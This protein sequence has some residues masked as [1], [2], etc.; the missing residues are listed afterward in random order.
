[1]SDLGGFS[2]HELFRAEAEQH[3][4][5]LSE[6]LVALEA[7][8]D[9]SAV[10]PLMRAA[11]SI[12]GAARVIGLEIAVGLSHAME[13]VLVAMQR[14]REQ[15]ASGRIDQLLRGT[16]LLASLARVDE[17]AVPEWTSSQA[18]AIAA[19][20]EALR[21]AVPAQPP[22]TIAAAP[23]VVD[24]VVV[25]SAVVDSPAVD[26]TAVDSTALESPSAGR[27][28]S[29]PTAAQPT[30]ARV[31]SVRIES[32]K[33]DRLLQL[34]GETMLESRRLAGVRDEALDLKQLLAQLG[35]EV[36][37]VRA[38]TADGSAVGGV[39][40]R[41]HALIERSREGV[42][43]HLATIEDAIRRGE[44]TST[45]LYNEVLASRMRPFG[46]L[47]AGLPRSVRDL[48]R[49][50]GKD[51]RIEI[52]GESVPVDRDVL[53]RIEAPLNHMIRNAIDHGIESADERRAAGKPAQATV[54]V[55]ARHQ[56]GQL[57]IVVSDDGRGIDLDALRQR[58][59]Q[60]ALAP[61]EMAEGLDRDELLEFLFLPGF[62]TASRVTEVSGR[63]VGLDVVQSVAREIGGTAR[64]STELGRGTAFELVLPVTLSVIR[65]L[66]AEI[67]GEI[68]AFPLARIERVIRLGSGDMQTVEGCMQCMIDGAAVGVIDAAQL[69]E[70]GEAARDRPA[71][72]MHDT[73]VV[74]GSG[75]ERFGLA[76]DEVAGEE[77]LVVRALDER[78]G[79]VPHL[80]AAALREDGEPVLIVDTEDIL[81]SLRVQLGQGQVRAARRRIAPQTEA[82]F[83][84]LVVDD[85]ATVREVE[86]QLLARMGFEVVTA[87]DGVD[88]WNTLREGGF[89]LVVS[90]IDMPRMNGIEFV[91]TL[92]ADDRFARIPVIVV[93]YKDREEDRLAGLEAGAT[94]YLTKGSFQDSSFT[95]T[96]RDL[97]DPGRGGGGRA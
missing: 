72:G 79:K 86:R 48:S 92:R 53:A 30:T 64:I 93:S 36:D 2:L 5:A 70:L 43:A 35:R 8:S 12:K 84:A 67:A 33:L 19:L 69:M 49:A 28:E 77:D 63:G 90:D 18:A 24:S 27:A 59:V 73:V 37:R 23:G 3:A 38:A 11:H 25:D 87:V 76:V 29:M 16:D 10:E 52:R 39:A 40:A 78:F 61:A 4:A 50:L 85:S 51:V 32:E 58:I 42:L 55:E 66:L 91:R 47:A 44:E 57:R 60:R 82:R 71:K 65:A 34:A 15:I 74:L 89:D 31:A 1:M 54:R 75:S 17:A 68:L 9:P 21:G 96:V 14:G 80:S 7:S 62:S 83:R 46:D 6:G 56:A 41:A 20:V 94:A 45:E 26:S 97:V 81:Q 88:G 22:A 95:D 13:D